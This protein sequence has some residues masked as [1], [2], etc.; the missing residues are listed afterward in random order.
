MLTGVVGQLTASTGSGSVGV[1]GKP[2][3]DWKVSSASGD[4]QVTIAAE[5]GYTLD[6]STTSGD[7]AVASGLTIEKQPGH[8]R[9]HGAVRGGGPT[10]RISTASGDI[11]VK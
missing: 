2:T 4:L 7:L 1:Q 5:Q 11:A 6:A 8:R 9:A 10:L 3:G